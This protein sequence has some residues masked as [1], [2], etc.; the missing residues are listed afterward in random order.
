MSFA[1]VNE[2]ENRQ[3][4]ANLRHK[5]SASCRLKRDEGPHDLCHIYEYWVIKE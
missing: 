4:T 2:G 3:C 1:E 5:E